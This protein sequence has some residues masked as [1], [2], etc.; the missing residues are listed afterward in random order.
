MEVILVKSLRKGSKTWG[1][2]GDIVKVKDGFGRNYLMPQNFAIRATEKNKRLIE[3]QRHILEEKNIQDKV[4]A[5]LEI[6]KIEGKDLSF[7]RQ[8]SDDGKLFG[9]VNNKEIAK[10][11]SAVLGHEVPH[12][13]VVMD[14][15]IKSLGVSSVE[16]MLHP[17]VT[18]RVLVVVGR[19]E[20]EAQDTLKNYKTAPEESSDNQEAM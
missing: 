15:P 12:S 20:S 1:K 8:S 10:G 3:E 14:H 18:T 11:L 4:R 16:I 2:I 13:A 6:K 19:S 17:E 9:S 7:V 5:E